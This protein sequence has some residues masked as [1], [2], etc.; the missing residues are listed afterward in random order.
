MPPYTAEGNGPD[1]QSCFSQLRAPAP[2]LGRIAGHVLPHSQVHGS[3]QIAGSID[4]NAS[5][6]WRCEV[7]VLRPPG[8]GWL[9]SL[10]RGQHET[11]GRRLWF[12]RV[13]ASSNS[14]A[15]DRPPGLTTPN[16]TELPHEPGQ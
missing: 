10:S 12:A 5:T 16:F 7:F 3:M 1:L 13:S 4:N 14:V 8:R 11:A 9:Q 2:L 6:H 15:G